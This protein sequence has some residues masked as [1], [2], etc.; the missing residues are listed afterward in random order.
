[1][2]M[3]ILSWVQKVMISLQQK[4]KMRAKEF[5][6]EQ[7]NLP[8]RITKPMPSTWVIPALQNQNAYL[9]YRFAVALAGARAVRN[10]D[11][12][13]MDKESVWGENQLVSGYMNPDIEEDIDFAL[14]EM[15]LSGKILVTS[16]DSEETSD[17]GIDSPIKGFKGYKRK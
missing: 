16:K 14:G 5:I 7:N 1:M 6:T 9:Q 17:T 15:G 2:D 13:K 11:I 8:D 10:G 4:T 3:L 12:P